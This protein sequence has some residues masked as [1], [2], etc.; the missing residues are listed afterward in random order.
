ME[1]QPDIGSRKKKED[2]KS[3]KK[4]N[5]KKSEKRNS[6]SLLP[7]KSELYDN[8]FPAAGNPV[9]EDIIASFHRELAYQNEILEQLKIEAYTLDAKI[10][11]ETESRQNLVEK[12]QQEIN[13]ARKEAEE[14][15]KERRALQY[16]LDT[17]QAW[18]RVARAYG[19]EYEC[20]HGEE[21]NG[22][23]VNSKRE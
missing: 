14:E 9:L 4:Q 7:G 17:L 16:Q 6:S 10:Y 3:Q 5:P 18:N 1:F 19:D 22:G 8:D 23:G 11:E 13:L 21:C 2:R 15:R 12:L 20:E